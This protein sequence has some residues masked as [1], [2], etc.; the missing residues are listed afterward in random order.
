MYGGDKRIVG[1]GVVGQ[2]KI[3]LLWKVYFRWVGFFELDKSDLDD[4]RYTS[5]CLAWA[6]L[7]KVK[8]EQK[9]LDYSHSL[10]ND[11]LLAV[12]SIGVCDRKT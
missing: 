1:L 12:N 9:L 10:F 5:F 8:K 6:R 3:F 11:N 2:R 7:G 4:V